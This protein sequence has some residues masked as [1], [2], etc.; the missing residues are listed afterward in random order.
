MKRYLSLLVFLAFSIGIAK[1][2]ECKFAYDASVRINYVGPCEPTTWLLYVAAVGEIT[3]I[4]D[5]G[6]P[7]YIRNAC[8]GNYRTCTGGYSN[9]G[10][11]Y[12]GSKSMNQYLYPGHVEAWW[13]SRHEDVY[14]VDCGMTGDGEMQ[15]R[16]VRSQPTSMDGWVTVECY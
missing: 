15:Y 10:T 12:Q 8:P 16:E 9:P 13:Y 4:L 7:A 5:G 11:V 14:L 3:T 2:N 1:A 6:W